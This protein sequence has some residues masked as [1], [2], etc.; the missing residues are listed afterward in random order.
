MLKGPL[1][2]PQRTTWTTPMSLEDVKQ[3]GRPTG[4]TVNDVALAALA[5]A[6]AR[7]PDRSR[8]PR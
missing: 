7:L 8:Q 1:S 6:P 2:A 3:I 4:A 5:G